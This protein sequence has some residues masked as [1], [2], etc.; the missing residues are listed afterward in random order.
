MR[1]SASYQAR[2]R[3]PSPSGKSPAAMPPPPRGRSRSRTHIASGRRRRLGP[4]G[5]SF[6][7]GRD[8]TASD[9]APASGL[10]IR[11]LWALWWRA[12]RLRASVRGFQTRARSSRRR[13]R[14]DFCVGWPGAVQRQNCV[15]Q[16]QHK[17]VTMDFPAPLSLPRRERRFWRRLAGHSNLSNLD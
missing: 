5:T 2:E 8:G 12:A 16:Q 15:M 1:W 13:R 17:S 3:R 9:L 10:T 11:Q 6:L 7:A 4:K 14:C